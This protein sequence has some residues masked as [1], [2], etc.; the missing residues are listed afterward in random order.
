[1]FSVVALAGIVGCAL[2]MA[3]AVAW[4]YY[5]L[6]VTDRMA[7]RKSAAPERPRPALWGETT[8]ANFH[9]VRRRT[10][11]QVD[12]A[13]SYQTEQL[14][15]GGRVTEMSRDGWRIEGET[16]LPVGTLMSL[17]ICLPGDVTQVSIAQAVVRWS[18]GDAFGIS[19]LALDPGPAAQLSEFFSHLTAVAGS[20]L[21]SVR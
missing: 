14:A 9:Y 8:R 6:T 1:M 20:T 15:G 10:R 3:Q 19:L 17:A 4:L 21:M 5:R 16:A 12:C 2:I 11:Y 18:E 7:A 13:V